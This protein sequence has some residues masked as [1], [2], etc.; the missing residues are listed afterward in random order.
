MKKKIAIK[1]TSFLGTSPNGAEPFTIDF[2]C[3]YLEEF[4]YEV[5]IIGPEVIPDKLKR[6]KS[7]NYLNYLHLPKLARMFLHIPVSIINVYIYCKRKKPDLIMCVGGV[8]YN[9][10]SVFIVGKILGIKHLVRTA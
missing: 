5:E 6:Y 9:G 1:A 2:F 7:S 4:G 10:L 8:F 3:E